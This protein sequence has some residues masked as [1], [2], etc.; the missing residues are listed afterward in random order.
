MPAEVPPRGVVAITRIEEE[1]TVV[2]GF[3]LDGSEWVLTG[4]ECGEL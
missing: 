3:S 1:G 4:P 2:S